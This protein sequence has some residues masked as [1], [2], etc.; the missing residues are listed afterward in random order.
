M[1][2]IRKL[3]PDKS[4]RK[5]RFVRNRGIYMG[6]LGVKWRKSR[7]IGSR[8]RLLIGGKTRRPKG[9]FGADRRVRSIHPSGYWEVIV[10]NLDELESLDPS[11][12]AARISGKV[13]LMKRERILARADELRIRVLN[14]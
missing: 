6:R 7:G 8:M 4:K 10:S 9:G 1:I 11:S 2:M 5:P 12:Q 3:T 14:R 13:G